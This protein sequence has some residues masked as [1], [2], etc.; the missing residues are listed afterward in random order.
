MALADSKALSNPIADELLELLDGKAHASADA[1]CGEFF[2]PDEFV[3]ARATDTQPLRSLRD[4]DEQ[5]PY[6]G[7]YPGSQFDR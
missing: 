1:D 2:L 3:N 5:R 7:N 6:R 4:T